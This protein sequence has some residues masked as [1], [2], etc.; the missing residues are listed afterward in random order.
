MRTFELYIVKIEPLSKTH[1]VTPNTVVPHNYWDNQYTN[2]D[3]Q[4]SLF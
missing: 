4:H 1:F 2:N 3:V